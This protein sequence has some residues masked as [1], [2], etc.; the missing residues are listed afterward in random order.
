MHPVSRSLLE[1]LGGEGQRLLRESGAPEIVDVPGMGRY[2]EEAEQKWSLGKPGWMAGAVGKG[3]AHDAELCCGSEVIAHFRFQ[4]SLRPDA[5]SALEFL[6]GK[7]FRL[8]IVSGDRQ[9]KVE[10]AAELL[11]IRAEDAHFGLLPEKKEKIV[12]ETDHSD[13]LYL[14]DGANDSL[15]FNAAWTTGTPVV[16]RS[17]LEVK[18]DFYFLGQSLRFLPKMMALSRRRWVTVRTAFGFAVVYNLVAITAAVL[19]LMNP[20]IAAIIMP[21]S[22]AV[23]LGIVAAGL[24][25]HRKTV[26]L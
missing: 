17:L 3:S 19:G 4:E 9:E 16:D 21:A 15:A 5:V 10:A 11:G 26:D 18:S 23:T 20:L 13:S 1:A 24:R 6:R 12:R 8:V 7:G 22:S 25:G 14:G 2:F